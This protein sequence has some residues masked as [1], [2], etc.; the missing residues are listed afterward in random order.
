MTVTSI[1]IGGAEY[2]SKINK[3][4]FSIADETGGRIG[5]CSFRLFDTH[6][7]IAALAMGGEVIVYVGATKI[8][9]G[10]LTRVEP[11]LMNQTI[12]TAT[13]LC[14]DYNSLLD[15]VTVPLES[16]AAQTDEAILDDLFSEYLP[17]VS[18]TAVVQVQASVTVTFTNK[19]LRQCV[20]TL[21]NLTGAE[22]Y[23]DADKALQYYDPAAKAVNIIELQES[24]DVPISA[25]PTA[26]DG[27]AAVYS[28]YVSTITRLEEDT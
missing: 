20:E 25:G 3:E 21:M 16:Y 6:A 13:C 11:R 15:T 12:T 22:G 10:Y 18:T 23:V 14:Q 5:T 4:D 27:W 26:L 17:V 7:N 24:P 8:F 9:G 1:T 28:D 2:I 19:T